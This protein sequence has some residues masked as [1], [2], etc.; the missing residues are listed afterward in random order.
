MA[1]RSRQG[2]AVQPSLVQL[3]SLVSDSAGEEE[4]LHAQQ[5]AGGQGFGTCMHSLQTGMFVHTG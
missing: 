4:L 5:R 1:G 2:K 3:V